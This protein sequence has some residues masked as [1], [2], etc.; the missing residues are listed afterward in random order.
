MTTD[1]IEFVQRCPVDGEQRVGSRLYE[2]SVRHVCPGP[3]KP[4]ECWLTPVAIAS[5]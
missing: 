1:A 2:N 3:S 5:E 4:V